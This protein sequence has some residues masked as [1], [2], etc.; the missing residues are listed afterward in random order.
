VSTGAIAAAVVLIPFA[1]AAGGANSFAAVRASGERATVAAP[2]VAA[3][4]SR[5]PLAPAVCGTGFVPHDLAHTT[6]A[7][8]VNVMPYDTNGSGLAVG[9]LD[10]NGTPDLVLGA[11]NGTTSILLNQGDFRF[12]R[13]ELR[14]PESDIADTETKAIAIV[15]ADHDG[16][17]DI[18]TTHTRGSVTLWHGN[19]DGTFTSNAVEELVAPAYS[20]FWDDLDGDGDLDLVT[21]SYDAMLE[22]ELK[23]SFLH[24]SGGGLTVYRA[25]N[26]R[27]VPQRVNRATQTL[28]MTMFDLNADGHRDLVVGNDFGVPDM[29]YIVDR[30]K[31]TEVKPFKRITRN[32][33][34]Y[35][36]GDFDGNGL[37]D[38]FATDMK[39]NLGNT[40]EVAGWMPLMQRSYERL[41]RKDS[42]RAENVLQQQTT[43]GRFVN[44]G[45]VKGVDATGWSWSAQ[46]GDLDNNGTL[47]LYVVNGMIDHDLLPFLPHS[48]IVEK[49]VAFSNDGKGNFTKAGGW[50]LE[51]TRSGRSMAFA[52][53]NGDGR[54]DVVVNN[55]E[56]ASVVYE[57]R[58]CGGSSIE[59]SL[60]WPAHQNVQAF[61]ST[62]TVTTAKRTLTRIVQPEGGYLSWLDGQ[63]NVGIP[64]GEAVRSLTIRWP[65]GTESKIANA[66]VNTRL[67]ITYEGKR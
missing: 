30:A 61:G 57:N 43:P 48:E 3:G 19:A 38:L 40:R 33:M 6:R 36:V 59:V 21:A 45:Y 28:A 25:T 18:V 29:F 10:G 4:V 24:S 16:R 8:D 37:Q 63:I 17:R 22:A 55:L 58:I 1:V 2:A 26:G 34:G 41:Q 51:S 66:E 42:Q 11:L 15:D 20:M 9:D 39:P 13:R 12:A 50:G 32:T 5:K 53:F 44:R 46:F 27:L 54:L 56:S 60:V 35:A 31:L 23:D 67:Q 65:D 64:N 47:D 7:R 14:D 62:V 49:N 52:D